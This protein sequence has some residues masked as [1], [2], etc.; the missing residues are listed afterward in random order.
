MCPHHP[1]TISPNVWGPGMHASLAAPPARQRPHW[2]YNVCLWL[3]A[4][5][6]PCLTHK[7]DGMERRRRLSARERAPWRTRRLLLT[8]DSAIPT[9][10]K[11]SCSARAATW[12]HALIRTPSLCKQPCHAP[13]RAPPWGPDRPRPC[14]APD[15]AKP[16]TESCNGRHRQARSGHAHS[17]P[18]AGT[19]EPATF[20]SASSAAHPRG[21][22]AAT[23]Q[24]SC[25]PR[26]WRRAGWPSPPR[27]CASCAP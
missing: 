10:C 3:R 24:R 5:Q 7:V 27:Q 14:S 17:T 26:T 21:T 19:P 2:P 23:A 8:L 11:L 20:R 25:R 15:L 1:P 13:C 22:G 16:E 9:L 18:P 12:P 4:A 6:Q